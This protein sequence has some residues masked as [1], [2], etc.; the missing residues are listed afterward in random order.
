MSLTYGP[1]PRLPLLFEN[2]SLS[3]SRG[4]K[5]GLVGKNG[6]GKTKL[7]EILAGCLEPLK[8]QVVADR[9][10]LAYLPQDP[11]HNF[12]GTL[13]VFLSLEGP[14]AKRHA[15]RLGLASKLETEYDK[16][17]Y[18]EKT[19][20]ALA[21]VLASEPETLLLDEPTNHLDVEARRWLEE[22]LT[23]SRHSVLM[24]CHD[25]AVLNASVSRVLELE[26]GRL[27]EY[28][29]GYDDMLHAKRQRMDREMETWQKNRDEARRLKGAAEKQFQSAAGM[30]KRPTT[31]TYDPKAKAFYKGKEAKLDRRAKAIRNR[32]EQLP[33]VEKPRIEDAAA[34]EFPS[35]PLRHGV[36]LSVR[37]LSKSF[38]SRIILDGVG[39]TLERGERLAVVGPNGVGKTTLFR[40]LLGEQDA[41]AGEFE[42]SSDARIGYLSQ[43]RITLD[44][45]LPIIE[46][47]APATPDE[48][49]FAR[50]LL[51]RLRIRADA[52]TKP[53][54]VLS[55]GERTKAELVKMLMTPVNVLILDEPTNHLDIDSLEA[56]ESAIEDYPGCIL[57]SSHD[58]TFV[59]KVA[60]HELCLTGV[61]S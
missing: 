43:G 26:G 39:F 3:L 35:R 56:L 13:E 54:G 24:V 42:W 33:S 11:V 14:L 1:D 10:R 61:S 51:G 27:I 48:E 19:R 45:S 32:V 41:D 55:V 37:G 17:S 38:G 18:G 59:E 23:T 30:T 22:F 50:T 60:H 31:R 28:S 15:A 53:V 6:A 52:A 46:A 21:R 25:R 5:V 12:P 7:L 29:G 40:I 2:L 34:L 49:H 4:E 47:L 8:G 9:S 57:F 16:L 44:P 36:A 20:A 58:R